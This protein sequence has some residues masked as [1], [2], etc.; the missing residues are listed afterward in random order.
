MNTQV[1]VPKTRTTVQPLPDDPRPS[2]NYAAEPFGVLVC[3]APVALLPPDPGGSTVSC[4][5]LLLAFLV[6]LTIWQRYLPAAPVLTTEAGHGNNGPTAKSR[7]GPGQACLALAL[8]LFLWSGALV[9]RV[10]RVGAAE[11][12]LYETA[13][14]GAAAA[15]GVGL[16]IG[17]IR[18]G[19][20]RWAGWIALVPN[21]GIVLISL[22]AMVSRLH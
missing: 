8:G 4:F 18:L 9:P 17:G 1:R 15:L 13:V 16:A 6:P 22:T 12:G 7:L 20:P 3:V 10:A 19:Y 21:A 11:E 2:A 14:F 5:L